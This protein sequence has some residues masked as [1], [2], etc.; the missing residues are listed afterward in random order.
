[1]LRTHLGETLMVEVSSEEELKDVDFRK[2]L[3]D[4]SADMV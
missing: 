2:D 4:L 3:D 1:M